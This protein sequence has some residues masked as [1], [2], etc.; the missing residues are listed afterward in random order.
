MSILDYLTF[1]AEIKKK[2]LLC[3][4]VGGYHFTSNVVYKGASMYQLHMNQSPAT[5]KV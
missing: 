1:L 4:L 5:N 2:V 3:E